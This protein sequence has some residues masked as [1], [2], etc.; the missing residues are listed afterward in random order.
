MTKAPSLDLAA[1]AA[2]AKESAPI[3][4][5]R[6]AESKFANNPF[7]ELIK[8]AGE[9]TLELPKVS[10]TE[11][12]KELQSYLRDAA[13]KNNRGLSTTIE[14]RGNG[15]VVKFAAKEKRASGG[16]ATCPVCNDEVTVTGDKKLRV[17]G[18][19]D[20]RCSGSGASVGNTE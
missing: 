13:D 4:R 10:S 19:R 20:A 6:T 2:S 8:R 5:T 1:F 12:A 11:E 3:T 7:V 15:Y 17:H 18:P 9:K 16:I 14:T